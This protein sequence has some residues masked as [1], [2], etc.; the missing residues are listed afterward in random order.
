M[1]AP[2]VIMPLSPNHDRLAFSCGVAALDAYLH[3]QAGQDVRRRV[4]NCFVAILP[5][6]RLI[7]GYYTLSAASIPVTDLPPA[8]AH[9]L[10]RY[11]IVPTA[12]VGRLAVDRQYAKRGLGGALLF[13]A[14]E[15]AANADPAIFALVVDAKDAHA[16]DF[17]RHFGFQ[18]FA[19][20]PMS[21]FLALATAAKLKPLPK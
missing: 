11:P 8:L 4:A 17:Y 9:R 3:R 19:S 16:A 5:D 2:F 12:L 10:P 15:R 20:R 13:D 7:A 21:F 6:A 18:P 14:L 1:T